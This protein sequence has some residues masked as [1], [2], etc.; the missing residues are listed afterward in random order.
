MNEGNE[1][2]ASGKGL[3]QMHCLNF[4]MEQIS[5]TR[6]FDIRLLFDLIIHLT[7]AV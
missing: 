6:N 1:Y 7:K 2:P 3:I 4:L 5:H